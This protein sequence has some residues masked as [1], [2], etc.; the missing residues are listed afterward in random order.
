[1]N[2]QEKE[3]T[4]KALRQ[5]FDNAEASFVIDYKGLNVSQI[6]DL[7]RRLRKNNGQLQVAKI[8]LIKRALENSDVTSLAS[9]LENQVAV[10]F[11]QKEPPTVAKVLSEFSKEYD[12]VK[13]LG[14]SFESSLLTREEVELFAS[15]PSREVLLAKLCGTLQAPITAL[16]YVLN[17]HLQKLLLVL[18]SIEEQKKGQ[19]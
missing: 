1:M 2:R 7:R 5:E 12:Q 19:Q 3:Q 14:G 10:V 15:L 18:K 8:T 9:I 6:T 17:A 4:V 16:A 13:I 11:A